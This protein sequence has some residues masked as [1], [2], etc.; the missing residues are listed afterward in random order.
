[1]FDPNALYQNPMMGLGMNLLANSGPSMQPTSFGQRLGQAG[2]GFMEQQMLL[3]NAMAKQKLREKQTKR[4]DEQLKV[5]EK[6]MKLAEKEEQL[7]DRMGSIIGELTPVAGDANM[8]GAPTRSWESAGK[9]LMGIGA[10]LNDPNVMRMG[11]GMQ[12]S[13]L[14]TRGLGG[15]ST[16]VY[17]ENPMGQQQ[18]HGVSR[19]EP[20]AVEKYREY[21]RLQEM[22]EA[23]KKEEA[24]PEDEGPG[25]FERLF[26]GWGSDEEEAP[27]PAGYHP[28]TANRTPP[29]MVG[30]SAPARA[31]NAL[32]QRAENIQN[33]RQ[34]AANAS[35][36]EAATLLQELEQ[37][38]NG[39]PPR[40]RR[41]LD[42]LILQLRGRL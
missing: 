39:T 34:R 2:L 26:S 15:G 21:M 5:I 30:P 29:H 12:P 4:I 8:P 1:M 13:E 27:K 33:I 32:T 17:S 20:T 16:M 40:Q 3:K 22:L 7:R 23:Q 18:F 9:E 25:F 10:Q 24:P 36:Q 28:R 35:P 11:L 42:R 41:S 37:I 14:K 19:R 38:R 6:E 31:F